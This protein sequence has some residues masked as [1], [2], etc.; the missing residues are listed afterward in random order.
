MEATDKPVLAAD[1]ATVPTVEEVQGQIAQE[2]SALV[3]WVLSCQSLTFFAFEMEL[4]PRVLALGCLFIQL[5]LC[6]REAQFQAAH[7][8]PEPRYR[9][10]GPVA[11]WLGTSL[12]RCVM[13]APTGIATGVGTTRWMSN[14]G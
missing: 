11:R 1:S 4:V 8:Q 5:F 14:W 3:T 10:Q 13:C 9:R 12:G 6:L 7:P 2:V